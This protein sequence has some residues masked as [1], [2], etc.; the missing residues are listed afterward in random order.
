MPVS[1]DPIK[2]FL[3]QSPEHGFGDKEKEPSVAQPVQH[4]SFRQWLNHFLFEKKSSGYSSISP[5]KADGTRTR[6]FFFNGN[7]RC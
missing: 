5:R 4:R 2:A 3:A 6:L 7:G 1:D